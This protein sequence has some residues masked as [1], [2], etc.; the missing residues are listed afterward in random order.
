MTA[1][2][3]AIMTAASAGFHEGRRA[4]PEFAAV[5]RIGD[6]GHECFAPSLRILA[7]E[8]RHTQRRRPRYVPL[9]PGYCFA[10]F[11]K[12]PPGRSRLAG[13]REVIDLV[14]MGEDP[15]RIPVD[16]IESLRA[17]DETDVALDITGKPE[18]DTEAKPARAGDKVEHR[19]A[20]WAGLEA[21]VEAVH[22]QNA[23]ILVQFLG[24]RRRLQ[25]PVAEL[26]VVRRRGTGP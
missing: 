2:W 17:L 3:Y 4:F 11:R 21:E 22:R 20:Q 19:G 25:V 7:R 26:E 10:N 18:K 24:A 23:T 16:Q 9:L 1:Q 14:R 6:E 15:Y 13:W 12:G 8:H 5:E